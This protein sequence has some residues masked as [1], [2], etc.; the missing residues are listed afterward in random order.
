MKALMLPLPLA[1]V[2]AA[3]VIVARS[4]DEPIATEDSAAWLGVATAPVD[5]VVAAQLDLPEGIGA[6]VKIVVPDS[7]AEGSGVMKNDILFE[8]DGK[9]IR[10]PEHL[11]ELVRARKSGD[12]VALGVIQRGKK[13]EVNTTLGARPSDLPDAGG[14][15]QAFGGRFE[16]GDLG[17]LEFDLMPFENGL[18]GHEERMEKMR[19][20][21]EKHFKG[22]MELDGLD[23]LP[24]AMDLLGSSSRSMSMSDGNGSIEIRAKDGHTEVTAKDA[25][26][27]VLFDGPANT[28]EERAKLPEHARAQLE[29]F[30]KSS[31]D[32]NFKGFR[33]GKPKMK[34]PGLKPGKRLDPKPEETPIPPAEDAGKKIQL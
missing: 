13:K 16:L 30:E 5:E 31:V 17:G 28:D 24:G 20:Q 33:F 19:L 9:Q 3:T 22:M 29:K 6:A 2:T 7:P 32:L 34:V 4:A 23:N 15:A 21:M 11:G 1:V 25:D 14:G 10:S 8:F 12:E 26:G 18:E 27:K